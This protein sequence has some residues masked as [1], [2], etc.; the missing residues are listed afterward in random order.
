M[1]DYALA[2]FDK[3]FPENTKQGVECRKSKSS[4]AGQEHNFVYFHLHINDKNAAK[5]SHLPSIQ[6]LPE[7]SGF[8]LISNCLEIISFRMF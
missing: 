7:K 2:C 6:V 3:C 8:D 4:R 1:R 5:Y